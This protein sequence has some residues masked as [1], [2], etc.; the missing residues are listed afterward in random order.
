MATKFFEHFVYIAHA[1]N[2]LGTS[3]SNQGVDLFDDDDGFYYDVLRYPDGTGQFMRI[4]SMVGLIPL[5]AVDT[6]DESELA[7]MAG[8]PASH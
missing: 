3:I 5:L 8:L 6:V 7:T 2:S 4:R 1:M